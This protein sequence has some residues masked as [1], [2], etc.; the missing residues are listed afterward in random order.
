VQGRVSARVSQ[1]GP[2]IK[3]FRVAFRTACTGAG[4]RIVCYATSVEPPLAISSVRRFL[5]AAA[6]Q[7]TG[8]KTRSVF[9]RYNIASA[10]DLRRGRQAARRRDRDNFRDNQPNSAIRVESLK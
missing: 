10:G 9:E 8:H 5:R 3:S 6:M 2:A 4:S 7:M 1:P